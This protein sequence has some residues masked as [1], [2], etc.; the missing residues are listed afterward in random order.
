LE[1]IDLKAK[2]SLAE[3]EVGGEI[4]DFLVFEGRAN[5]PFAANPSSYQAG[6]RRSRG[7][8]DVVV[9][10]QMKRWHAVHTISLVYRDAFHNQLNA[11]YQAQYEDYR[12]LS[13]A[14][15]DQT[16][17]YG[18]GVVASP[19]PRPPRALVSPTSANVAG[20]TYFVRISWVDGSGRESAASVITA[21]DAPDAQALTVASETAPAVVTGFHVFVGLSETVQA[22]QT[23]TPLA[24]NDTL[25]LS[26][27]DLMP[28]VAPGDGQNPDYYVTAARVVR[29]G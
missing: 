9:N 22:R 3:D 17:K 4:L 24:P 25:T 23:T 19:V 29:R 10:Q 6:D 1:G 14:G 26:V 15:R 28:G 20:A 12:R 27:A 18:I 5:D 16:F 8:S 13:R 7:V 11:R 2:L 21:L